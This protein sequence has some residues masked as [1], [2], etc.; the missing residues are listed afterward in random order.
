MPMVTRSRNRVLKLKLAGRVQGFGLE[1]R[2]FLFSIGLGDGSGCSFS[3]YG[4]LSLGFR[5]LESH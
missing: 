4:F 5:A 1:F 2:V 3:G